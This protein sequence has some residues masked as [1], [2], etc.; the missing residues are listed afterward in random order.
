METK[1]IADPRMVL[2]MSGNFYKGSSHSLANP[3]SP[4]CYSQA[5][6][7]YNLFTL[8]FLNL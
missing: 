5:W 7:L 4:I 1:G 2:V 6:H 8:K 3:V